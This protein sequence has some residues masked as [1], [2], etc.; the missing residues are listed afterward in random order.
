M[1]QKNKMNTR[2]IGL[3]WEHGRVVALKAA[4]P[5]QFLEPAMCNK[6]VSEGA[7]RWQHFSRCRRAPYSRLAEHLSSQASLAGDH[8]VCS[9]LAA[10]PL[11]G[12]ACSQRD[13]TC[14]VVPGSGCRGAGVGN[15]GDHTSLWPRGKNQGE[16]G[17][18]GGQLTRGL[19]LCPGKNNREGPSEGPNSPTPTATHM[20]I[21]NTAVPSTFCL[22]RAC[23]NSPRRT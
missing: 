8:S 12:N 23:F 19:W 7:V 20:H 6:S 2:Q 3:G 16:N 4:L 10:R 5:L 17:G 1:S 13:D 18:R 11:L 15:S 14:E 21:Q 22:Q 9:V